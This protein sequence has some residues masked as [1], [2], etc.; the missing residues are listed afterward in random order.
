MEQLQIKMH[1]QIEITGK[2]CHNFLL[3][4][5]FCMNKTFPWSLY[6]RKLYN[7]SE[8]IKVKNSILEAKIIY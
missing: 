1:G 7:K 5:L 2:K 4:T 3:T 6:G 8:L